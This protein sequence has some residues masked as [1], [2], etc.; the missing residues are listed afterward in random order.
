MTEQTETARL[1][2]RISVLEER[3]N[4]KQ[5]EYKTDISRLSEAIAAR[6]TRLLVVVVGTIVAAAGLATAV[7]GL[8]I[9]WP[10]AG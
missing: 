8:I 4:T 10:I 6:E 3:M 1:S 5:A 9:R 7:L 2:E